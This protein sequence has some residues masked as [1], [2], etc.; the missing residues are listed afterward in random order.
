MAAVA[1][2]LYKKKPSKYKLKIPFL[3]SGSIGPE[4]I[5]L[6]STCS[7][8]QLFGIDLNNRFEISPGAKD[9]TTLSTFIEKIRS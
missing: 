5:D 3:L 8:P 7:H 6:I 2:S 9:I 1:R 4:D